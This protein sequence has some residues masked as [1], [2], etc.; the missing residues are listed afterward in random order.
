MQDSNQSSHASQTRTCPL[1]I[2]YVNT[3]DNTGLWDSFQTLGFWHLFIYRSQVQT[4]DTVHARLALYHFATLRF[5]FYFK[6]FFFWT[7]GK[8][9]HKYDWGFLGLTGDSS[10]SYSWHDEYKVLN[11]CP[12]LG[13]AQW[14]L[15]GFLHP[16]LCYTRMRTG[17]LYPRPM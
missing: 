6:Y 16:H 10:C 13:Q 2:V 17:V 1:H 8:S 4:K 9:F 12:A 15:R 3:G 7:S 14:E 5:N 11:I